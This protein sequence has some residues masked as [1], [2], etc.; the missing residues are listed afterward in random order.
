MLK[1]HNLIGNT[2]SAEGKISLQ[3]FSTIQ[4]MNLPE[5]FA[6]ATDAEVEQAVA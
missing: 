4:Q 3:V 5:K 1:G 6:A 2:E